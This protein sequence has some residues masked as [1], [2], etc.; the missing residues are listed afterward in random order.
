[1]LSEK[2]FAIVFQIILIEIKPLLNREIGKW[3]SELWNSDGRLRAIAGYFINFAYSAHAAGPSN[4]GGYNF[5]Y[6][7]HAAGT[8]AQN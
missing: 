5:V 1:M 6:S 7:A 8:P 2:I 4:D 3:L